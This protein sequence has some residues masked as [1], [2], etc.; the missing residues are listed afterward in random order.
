MG[1]CTSLAMHNEYFFTQD[2]RCARFTWI[3]G[4]QIEHLQQF[5][6]IQTQL[7]LSRNDISILST[8]IRINL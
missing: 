3:L 2:C 1:I 6:K 5:F 8:I 4:F 7:N